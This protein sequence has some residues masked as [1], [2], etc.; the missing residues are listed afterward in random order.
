[1]EYEYKEKIINKERGLYNMILKM[2]SSPLEW[3]EEPSLECL[4]QMISGYEY[5]IME[6][7]DYRVHFEYEFQEYMLSKFASKKG[8]RWDQILCDGRSDID[9]YY[10]FFEF[11]KD[12]LKMQGYC[13]GQELDKVRGE[14]PQ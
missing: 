9:A 13:T 3:M 2:E 10:L 4:F 11:F 6:L 5:A 12:F 1:M 14:I 8:L 7:D